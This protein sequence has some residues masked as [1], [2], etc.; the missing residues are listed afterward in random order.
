MT[1]ESVSG[2]ALRTFSQSS[3]VTG[4]PPQPSCQSPGKRKLLLENFINNFAHKGR[5][6]RERIDLVISELFHNQTGIHTCGIREVDR[7]HDGCGAA[8]E[9]MKRDHR[10]AG[11]VHLSLFGRVLVFSGNMLL[12]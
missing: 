4:A 12:G 11:H 1:C 7:G 9:I 3:K 6:T 5:R 8:A 10:E 2:N